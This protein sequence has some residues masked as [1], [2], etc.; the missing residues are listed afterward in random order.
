MPYRFSRSRS[1]DASLCVEALEDTI[2]KYGRPEIMNADQG[3]AVRWYQN[4]L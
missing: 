3:V 4:R 2:G 1:L